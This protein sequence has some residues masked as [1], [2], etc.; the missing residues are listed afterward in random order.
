MRSD[1]MSIDTKYALPYTRYLFEQDALKY[2]VGQNVYHSLRDKGIQVSFLQSHN[3]VTGIPGKTEAEAFVQGKN[4]LVVGVRKSLDFAGCKPSAH[5]QLPL[6]TGC[7]GMCQYCYLNTNLGKKPYTRLY[8][9]VDEILAKAASYIR[10]RQPVTTVFEASATSDPVPVEFFS[11]AL[12]RAIDY[13]AGEEFG[14]LR[15]ATKFACPDSILKACHQGHTR[16]RYSLNTPRIIT[17]Y[18][19]RTPS[20]NERISALAEVIDR[21]YPAGILLAPVFLEDGWEREYDELLHILKERL[22]SL[23]G[24]DFHFEIISHRFTRRAR[25]VI[26]K[27]FTNNQLPMDEQEGRRFKYGQFGYG[28][29]VYTADRLAEMKTFFASRLADLFPEAV[30]EYG[31]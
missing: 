31:I 5:F 23:N 15:M 11:G 13:F 8:V 20:L 17:R 1:K 4:T 10:A 26:D 25:Q 27:V 7:P 18:E 12:S 28:K 14:R 16:I 21:G 24:L 3:R 22:G 30:V 6:V 19:R 9:N 2:P 29:Y